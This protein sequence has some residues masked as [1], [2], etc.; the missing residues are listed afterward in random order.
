MLN[1]VL[2]L[3]K[4]LISIKSNP[5]NTKELEE[6]LQLCLKEL[7]G[8]N[9]EIFERNGVKSALIYNSKKRPK[10]FR[11]ILNG[12]LDV[13]PGKDFQYKPVIKGDK[14]YGVGALDMKA[15]LSCLIMTFKEI[16][17]KVSYPIALQLVTDEEVGGFDGTKY[18]VEEGIR[19]DFVIAGET[20]NFNIV[21]QAKGIMWL[22]ICSSGVTAHGAYPWRG[23]NAIW[24]MNEFLNKLKKKFPIPKEQNWI[25][26]V[27]LS[28]ILTANNT[29]NKIPDN[30]EIWLDIRYIPEDKKT[31][32]KEIKSMMTKDF[33]M[34]IVAN[35]PSLFVNENNTYIQSLKKFDEEI[36]KNKVVLYGAQGSSDARHFTDVG[37]DG[38]EFGP[39]GG[40]IGSDEEWIDIPSLEKYI[41]ILKIFLLSLK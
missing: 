33:K 36:T 12:H 25:T 11:I 24:E 3:S 15:N 16:A 6:C 9:V 17:S 19:A 18:Q 35:E 39:T 41:T 34:E 30:C 21:N 26:T 14:L 23:T 7:K 2:D 40:G 27:N 38:I 29:F 1:N 37:C 4:K 13:I 31:L 32:L 8:Y 20:T 5:G 28:K 22:K 10:K